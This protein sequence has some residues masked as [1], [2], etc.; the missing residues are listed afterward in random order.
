MR[1]LLLPEAQ[2]R[3][4]DD[5]THD[6]FDNPPPPYETNGVGA[7]R[8]VPRVRVA[9][10]KNAAKSKAAPPPPKPKPGRLS[11]VPAVETVTAL[12]DYE[13][14]AEGDLSFSAGDTIDIVQ[15]TENTNEW[16]VG[17]VGGRQGQ[18]PG[19]FRPMILR[20]GLY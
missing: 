16:W 7:P 20:L 9:I 4:V 13:A 2:Y 18:F 10:G 5:S 6:S 1:T 12:Y 8:Q 17:K 14:Q 19:E 11:G 15:R 3:L